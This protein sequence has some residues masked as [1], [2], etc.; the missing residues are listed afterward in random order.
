MTTELDF[1][2]IEEE[3]KSE[4]DD[5]I[6]NGAVISAGTST[7][8]EF[9]Q[10]WGYA[11][12]DAG[13]QMRPDTIIDI[14]SVTKVL[15]TTTA[16]LIA[17]DDG[18]I[19]FGAPFTNYLPEYMAPLENQITVRDLAMHISGFGSQNYYDASMGQDIR[20]N[21]LSASPPNPYGKLEYSCWN[22]QL[23]GMILENVAGKSLPEFCQ[24]RIFVPL[25]MRDTSLGKPLTTDLNRLAKTCTTEKAGMISDFIAV[26]LY[27]D[28]L[29]AGN[30]GCFSCAPDL[31]KFCR[32]LL[33]HGEY[34]SGKKLFSDYGFDAIKVPRAFAGNVKRSFGWI[35]AD[36]LKPPGFSEHTI[37]HSGWSGQTL[38][39]DF[40][41]DFYAVVLTIRTLNDYDRAK[42]GRFKLIMELGKNTKNKG[43]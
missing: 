24:E 38:F 26:R 17:R 29:T 4:L 6:I 39:L 28:G 31:A 7:E 1:S 14:A 10:A 37:Y 2:N 36:E 30:A 8:T 20:K 9:E 3:I 27:R 41:K 34:A 12:V 43:Y 21:I 19:D 23:L 5:G 13:I 42:S 25:G 40:E 22:F 15:A 11:D 18:L 32:C 33:N 35:V 16:L